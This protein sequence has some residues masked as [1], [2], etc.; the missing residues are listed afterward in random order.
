M[1][2]GDTGRDKRR[3]YNILLIGSFLELYFSKI[4]CNS[5]TLLSP[6]AFSPLHNTPD[7]A[8]PRPFGRF[9]ALMSLK[10][11]TKYVLLQYARNQ[12]DVIFK[13]A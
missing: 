13:T 3:K 7:S 8:R 1:A 10:Q 5:R 12:S 2:H 4:F 11:A 6:L 9:E